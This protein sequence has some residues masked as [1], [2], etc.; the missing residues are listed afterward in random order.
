M[1]GKWFLGFP[2]SKGKDCLNYFTFHTKFGFLAKWQ[3]FCAYGDEWPMHCSTHM[4][5]HSC[6]VI[7]Q[8][9]NWAC[10][11]H[12]PRRW[13]RG[14]TVFYGSTVGG[15]KSQP[16]WD[17]NPPSG[18]KN[19]GWRD[20]WPPCPQSDGGL[21]FTAQSK[22][23][24]VVEINPWFSAGMFQMHALCWFGMQNQNLKEKGATHMTANNTCF[25]S[26]HFSVRAD[27]KGNK[28]HF[29]DV[30]SRIYLWTHNKY[31]CPC[32]ASYFETKNSPLYV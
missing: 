21:L 12:C 15:F 17:L 3:A 30:T 13:L 28:V 25:N 2:V 4:C 8:Q 22:D 27:N 9:W 29:M 16:R 18:L 10:G 32:V 24:Q 23:P 6:S 5:L 11:M 31:S 26:H 19:L 14:K 7:S 1:A 20:C